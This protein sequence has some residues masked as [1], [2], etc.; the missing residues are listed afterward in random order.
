VLE[1]VL[2]QIVDWAGPGTAET[3]PDTEENGRRLENQYRSTK[4]LL[5]DCR[6]DLEK[7]WGLT[8]SSKDWA[9]DDI[10]NA[11]FEAH[12]LKFRVVAYG[13]VP[14]AGRSGRP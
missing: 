12:N 1:D 9:L 4:D 11:Q 8:E 3:L 2:R 14:G 6:A 10:V 13:Y 5:F 7:N